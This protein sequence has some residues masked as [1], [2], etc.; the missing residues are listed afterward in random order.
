M[1][2]AHAAFPRQVSVSAQQLPT[3][4][5][6]HG[7]PP[8]SR[9]Q[10][11]ASSG[12]LPQWPPLQM[13]PTQH[14]SVVWQFDPGGRHAPDPQTPFSQTRLQHSLG[15]PHAK[16]SSLHCIAPQTPLLQ[17]P[18]QHSKPLK[19][20]NP[21]GV[22]EK[23]HE[24]VLG[25][26]KPL[27]HWKSF[28]HNQPSGWQLPHAPV[29]GLQNWLQ[30]WVLSKQPK[31]SG[32]QLVKPHALDMGSQKPLQQ[33]KADMHGK[34]SG[35][36]PPAPHAPVLGLQVNEQQSK[37]ESQRKPSGRQ[38]DVQERLF[39]SQRP[40]QHPK[41]LWQNAPSG[42]HGPPPQKPP[43]HSN[44]QHCSGARHEDPGGRHS[45]LPQKPLKQMPSQQSVVTW[46]L[47]PEGAQLGVDWQ[48]PS[49]HASPEQQS[50]G[51]SHAPPASW[52]PPGPAS[53]RRSS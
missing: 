4:H 11:P 40:L 9:P 53:A 14:C 24:E 15:S 45:P 50:E 49:S 23:P 43:M 47:A 28:E 31:P 30:H 7:V 21:S 44:E 1:L 35:R 25:S 37:F 41:S 10:L 26:Q 39:R 3:T 12:E 2:E 32:T 8:G 17:R 5:W 46:Q 18:E 42:W 6:L 22:H 29:L 34:P 52:H 36:Q 19:H 48:T 27:Q 16:P 13:S 20:P 33:S 38:P 51:P